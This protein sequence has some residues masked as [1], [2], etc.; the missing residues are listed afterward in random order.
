MNILCVITVLI[1]S[2]SSVKK[3]KEEEKELIIPL[4]RANRWRG[5]K[6][7]ELE[8]DDGIEDV[9]K[10]KTKSQPAAAK[11]GDEVTDKAVQEII[12]EM[13]YHY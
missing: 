7:E 2:S 1:V 4:I 8:E 10:T 5:V 12:G 9:S 13:I 11:T 3:G 6:P